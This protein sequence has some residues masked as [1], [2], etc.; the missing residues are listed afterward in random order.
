[1]RYE[2]L[3]LNQPVINALRKTLK[4]KGL[5]YKEI[6]EQIDLSESSVKRLFS[7]GTF[8][9]ERFIEICNV[10]GVS[11]LDLAKIA[12]SQEV[13]MFHEYTIE[14]E[15]FFA[16]N[17]KYL[18]YFDQLLKM[19][20]PKRV[21]LVH[22]I[23]KQQTSDFLSKL[24]K[25][26]LIEWLPNDKVK[27]LTPREVVW[28]KNGELRKLLLESAKT[29]FLMSDFVN[30]FEFFKFSISDLSDSS[31]RRFRLKLEDLVRE[32]GKEASFDKLLNEKSKKVGLLVGMRPWNLSVLEK[33]K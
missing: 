9:L 4:S 18:A 24:E 28:R 33:L 31:I 14:Q 17:L 19:G 25:V 22:S 7:D 15:K 8:T 27:F 30:E 3:M 21:A 5:T 10:I 20:S 11:L 32:F 29:E 6:A 2:T 12:D 1:M 16:K 23:S 26:G 13:E